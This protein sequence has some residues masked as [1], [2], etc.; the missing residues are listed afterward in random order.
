MSARR[1]VLT[2]VASVAAILASLHLPPVLAQAT[3]PLPGPLARIPELYWSN[4]WRLLLV[5]ALALSA[6]LQSGL[7]LGSV[8]E[9]WRGV[10][11]VCGGPV[12]VVVCVY[13]FLPVQPFENASTVI[14]T[15]I[16]LN[17]DLL[18]F[19]FV[20][21]LLARAWEGRVAERVPLRWPLLLTASL[22]ALAH[23]NNLGALPTGYVVFQVGYAFLGG[24]LTGLARQWTGSILYGLATH[25]A[26]NGWVWLVSTGAA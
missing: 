8:R 23:L 17:E 19:G 2:L 3:W 16:P 18:H 20:Y 1:R 7:S 25:V 22:F 4:A 6:P 12:V 14:W 11:L 10:L 24:L 5:G 21:G 9:H 26:I 13:G 15:L